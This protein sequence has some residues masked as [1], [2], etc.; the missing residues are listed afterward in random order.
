MLI[1]QSMRYLFPAT[2]SFL[3]FLCSCGKM[4]EPT[5]NYIDN[6]KLAKPGFNKS[7]VTFDMQCFNHNN[8]RAKLKEEEGEAWLDS[9]Y[10]GHFYVDTMINIPAKSNFTVPIKLDVDMKKM[11]VYSLT[12]FKNEDVLVTVKGNARVGK[13]GFY[14]KIP[15]SYE[16]KQN[17][18]T[19]I[20]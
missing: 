12:R 3:V 6:I 15:L 18:G 7:L 16:G 8:S 2:I 10:L 11:L 14:K 1:L 9:N 13:G 19:L 17:L 5:L 20:K 4:E